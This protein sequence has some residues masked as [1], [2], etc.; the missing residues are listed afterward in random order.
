MKIG[1]S[2][3]GVVAKYGYEKGFELIKNAGFDAVDIGLECYG[4]REDPQDLYLASEDQFVDHFTNI[5]ELAARYEL[6]ISQTHGRCRTYTPELQQQEYA[7]WVSER[8]LKATAVLGAPACVIHQIS[9]G[10]WPDNYLDNAF[11]HKKNKEFFDWLI[12]YAETYKTSFSLETFGRATVYGNKTVDSWA[13]IDL[14]K[15]QF[16]MLDTEYKTI[17]VDTGHTNEA[18]P[19]G[20]PTAG[21]AIRML[22]KDV[23]LLHLHDNNGTYDQHL[24]PLMGDPGAVKWPDVFDA[25]DEVGYTGVYNFELQ[26]VRYYYALP[27]AIQFLGKFLRRFVD[28]RGRACR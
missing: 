5:R 17:C 14:L 7:R 11:M 2:C 18:V 4:K 3:R 1:I 10:R 21:E 12:P 24:P 6:E 26:L 25:L 8:D 20:K 15:E 23:T 9:S 22:G 27:E 13:D 19:F 28:D 16:N